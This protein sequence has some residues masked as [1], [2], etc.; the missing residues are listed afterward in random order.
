MND[1]NIFER[2]V[3]FCAGG[4]PLHRRGIAPT[5]IFTKSTDPRDRHAG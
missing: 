4:C 2:P 5:R 3:V 1:A